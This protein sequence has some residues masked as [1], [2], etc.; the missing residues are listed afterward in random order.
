MI[1]IGERLNSSRSAVLSAMAR[2]DDGFLIAQAQD[3]EKAG[4]AYIDLNCAALL[5]EE[6]AGLTWAVPLIQKHVKAPLSLDSPNPEALAAA[7]KIH[8]GRALLNS[9]SGEPKKL[10]ALLP[11][12]R[13]HRPKV[14]VLCLDEEG[15]PKDAEAVYSLGARLVERLLAQGLASEDIFLDALVHPVGVEAAA[16]RRFLRSLALL[17]ERLPQVRTIAGLSN[18]SFGLPERRLVNRTFLTLA[19]AEGL[20]AAILDPLDKDLMDTLVASEALLGRDESLKG[21]LRHA[22]AKKSSKTPVTGQ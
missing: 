6:A 15:A 21:F 19:L 1:I 9:L 2:R 16:P 8:R 10:A 17:K 7:L 5:E 22:R 13:E 14:I 3:Q 18:V 20:D 12:I 4:A 11:L